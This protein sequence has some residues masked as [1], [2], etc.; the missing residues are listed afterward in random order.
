MKFLTLFC[1]LAS[2]LSST[3]ND[4]LTRTQVYNFT[5]GDTFDYRN[6]SHND[7]EFPNYATIISITYTRYVVTN[8]YYSPDSATK[9]IVREQLFPATFNYTT[10]TL[11]NLT[12]QELPLDVSLAQCSDTIYKFDSSS[13]YH[14]RELNS[15]TQ[16]FCGGP[17]QQLLVVVEGIGIVLNYSDWA[18]MGLDHFDTLALVYYSKGSET[19]GTPYYNFPTVISTLNPNCNI[20]SLL[21]TVNSGAFEVKIADAKVL[22]VH[23]IVYDITGREVHQATLN[24]MANYFDITPCSSGIYIWKAAAHGQISQTGKIVVH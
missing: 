24:D 7:I 22:P 2:T 1:L 18:A 10:D 15:L 3:A 17:T 20:I 23:L 4:T 11:Q 5:V 8:I 16:S 6:Y 12:K 19:W 21:P 9:Y 14:M 13:Q